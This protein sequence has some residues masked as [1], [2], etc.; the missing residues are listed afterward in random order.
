M[1]PKTFPLKINVS[2][3]QNS[4][5]AEYLNIFGL[6]SCWQDT[7]TDLSFTNKRRHSITT[8]VN[9][10]KELTVIRSTVW[11]L[12]KLGLIYQQVSEQSENSVW[13]Y[14]I[15]GTKPMRELKNCMRLKP[16]VFGYRKL[17]L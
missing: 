5:N 16:Q 6:L 3:L 17:G 2:R 15:P 1:F 12:L 10:L 14:L 7:E 4:H 13:K 9:L 11:W 8:N